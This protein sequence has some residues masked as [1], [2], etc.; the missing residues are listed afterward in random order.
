MRRVQGQGHTFGHL[1]T[2]FDFKW[3]TE[4]SGPTSIVSGN[5]FFA[6]AGGLFPLACTMRGAMFGEENKS[7]L[8]R[9]GE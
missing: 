5:T 6:N 2:I 3:E 8:R 9:S 1:F 7:G 4:S